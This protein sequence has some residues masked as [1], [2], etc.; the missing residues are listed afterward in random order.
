MLELFHDVESIPIISGDT[1]TGTTGSV[2]HVGDGLT[3]GSGRQ[4]T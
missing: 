1:N 3:Q 4:G 2:T